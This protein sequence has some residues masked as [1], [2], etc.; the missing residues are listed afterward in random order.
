MVRS[1]TGVCAVLLVSALIAAS[2]ARAETLRIHH[3]LPTSSTT[4]AKFLVPWAK[5]V[6]EQ[7]G[8]RLKFQVYPSMQMGGKPPQLYDQARDGVADLI[9][10]LPGYTAGRFP[11]MEALELPFMVS[12]AESTSQAAWSF[13]DKYGR[14]EFKD[15]HPLLLHVHARGSFHLRGHPVKALDDL[16]GL[17]VRAPSR[18]I[19][20]AL[21]ALGATPVG[22]PVPQVP[23]SLSKGV[24]DG[25]VIPYEVAASLKVPELVDSHT[26]IGGPRGFY[27]ALF[28]FAM[29]KDKYNALPKDLQKI[30]D[31]NSGLPLAKEI[32]RLWDEEEDAGRKVAADRGNAIT[33]I[34]PED[35]GPWREQSQ[36]VIDAWVDARDKEGRDGAAMLAEARALIERYGR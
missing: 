21:K 19:N 14:E 20:A 33:V 25:A 22:M 11:V 28:L 36:P 3:F 35:L 8:G 4:H 15:V 24:I 2:P 16:K 6:E 13:Y 29:N 12:T 10:T 27:T 9:W 18:T 5:R 32:G 17:K 1:L 23:Q 26:E 34:P 7:S 31:D 30:I